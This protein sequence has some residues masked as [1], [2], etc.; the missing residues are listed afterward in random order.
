MTSTDASE[1]LESDSSVRSW[2]P[3]WVLWA[4]S[5]CTDRVILRVANMLIL[6]RLVDG[7]GSVSF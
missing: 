5:K 1:V 2:P 3:T 7:A 6:A 4:L